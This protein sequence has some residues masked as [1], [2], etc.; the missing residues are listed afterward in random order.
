M[1]L[2]ASL[3]LSNVTGMAPGHERWNERSNDFWHWFKHTQPLHSRGSVVPAD[4]RGIRT[5]EQY[6]AVAREICRNAARGNP[7]A[8]VKVRQR[9]VGDRWITDYLIWYHP[10]GVPQGLFIVVNDC[11]KHGEIETMFT[12]DDGRAYFDRQ[13]GEYPH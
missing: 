10:P 7:H 12:P 2:Y 9:T 6:V 4:T 3:A 1:S 8:Q 13:E 5:E 11:G